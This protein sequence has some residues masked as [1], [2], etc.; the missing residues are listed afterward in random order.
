VAPENQSSIAKSLAFLTDTQRAEAS[1]D[2]YL[3]STPQFRRREQNWRKAQAVNPATPPP[4]PNDIVLDLVSRLF[5]GLDPV[6]QNDELR[7]ALS[8]PLQPFATN[9]TFLTASNQVVW[10]AS[11]GHGSELPVTAYAAWSVPNVTFQEAHFGDIALTGEDLANYVGWYTGLAEAQREEWDA[12]LDALEPGPGLSEVVRAFTFTRPADQPSA[13]TPAAQAHL[14]EY[15][16][17]LL[18]ANLPRSPKGA[19]SRAAIRGAAE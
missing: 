11:L 14:A 12:F 19:S 13:T 1:L 5:F 6:S 4:D 7:V 10:V 8:V 16:K 18:L 17:K 3:R 2:E 9:G 15:V